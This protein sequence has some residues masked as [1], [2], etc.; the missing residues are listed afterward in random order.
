MV[1]DIEIRRS[2]RERLA[3]RHAGEADTKIVEELGLCQGVAR[4]DL[5]VVN[6]R[7]HG[8][9]IK[10]ESDT[11]VRLPAQ[12]EAYCRA[13]EYVTIVVSPSH[14]EKVASLVPSWWGVIRAVKRA[15]LL[16]L[17]ESKKPRRNPSIR[18]LALA[19]F[20]WRDE[21]LQVLADRGLAVGMRSK[22]RLALWQRLSTAVA[23][24]EL[25]A[26][27]R[28]KLKQRRGDWRSHEP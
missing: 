16:R 20:L 27:V 22:P 7:L 1:H 15:N 17:V 25:G 26:I 4:V 3:D 14:A 28:E 10:S 8:Y 6:G 11:L 2:L 12:I 18:P 24:D 9:E 13:L 23:V 19:Q 5:A 21:A